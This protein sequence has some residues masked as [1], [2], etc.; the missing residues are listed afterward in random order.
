MCGRFAFSG[1]QWPES[2]LI[3]TPEIEPNFNISPQSEVLCIYEENESHKTASMKWGFRP[4]WNK[5][6][7]I[8]PIN[9]RIESISDKPMF[10]DSFEKR[11]CLI[12]ATGWYEWKKSPRGKVPFY[13]HL[14]KNQP[15]LFAG[16]YDIKQDS[17]KTFCILTT[18][19]D[20]TI[21]HIHHRMPLIIANDCVNEW[22][23]SG[24]FES[25]VQSIKVHPVD[26]KVNSITA[27]GI[28]LT[29][30]IRT[31]FD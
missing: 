12:P 24:H 11:R 25:H 27:Q 23:S 21:S 1:E 29:L 28:E 17:S 14:E 7:S 5:K 19:S 10:R 22:L 18:E 31:L 20:E 3:Q 15:I 30:P 4:S 2:V 26:R 9:A 16:I 6:N 13:H 8:T